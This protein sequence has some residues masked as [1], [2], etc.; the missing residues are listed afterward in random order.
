MTDSDDYVRT[1]TARK[2][3]GL[4]WRYP[5]DLPLRSMCT[6]TIN[7]VTDIIHLSPITKIVYVAQCA[8]INIY[9]HTVIN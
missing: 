3:R 9:F 7:N 6:H 1:K 2:I 5:F 8:D 4:I